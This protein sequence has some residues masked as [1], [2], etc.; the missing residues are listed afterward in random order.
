VDAFCGLGRRHA[1]VDDRHVG[2]MFL[3]STQEQRRVADLCEDLNAGPLEELGERLAD[4]GR[5]VGQDHAQRH[6]AV[7]SLRLGSRG[8]GDQPSR[9]SSCPLGW[10][11]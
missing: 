6:G 9:L 5:V 3:D 7:I 10:P 11:G 1:D 2:L 4:Q 8:Q